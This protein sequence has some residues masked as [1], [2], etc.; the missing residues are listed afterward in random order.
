MAAAIIGYLVLV[1]VL[2]AL[3]GSFGIRGGI[4][5]TQL[6]V[7]PSKSVVKSGEV[8]TIEVMVNPSVAIAGGQFDLTYNPAALQVDSVAEGDLFKQ[9]GAPTYFV[10][11]VIDN[12]SGRVRDIVDVV[13]GSGQVVSTPGTFAIFT[14]TAKAAG[15]PGTLGLDRV[16][17][18][19][20]DGVAVPLESPVINDVS[21]ASSSDLNGDGTIDVADLV[22]VLAV[23][24]RTGA[25]AWRPEDL[26][27]DGIINVLDLVL[28]AQAFA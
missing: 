17:I 6:T 21:V 15:K 19:N 23:W 4:V 2:I 25:P 18:G 12:A 10:P 1:L 13:L 7:T 14:C 9:G 22:L 16:I 11:G 20:K 26:A 5:N 28:V 27:A 24:G 3:A 8:F